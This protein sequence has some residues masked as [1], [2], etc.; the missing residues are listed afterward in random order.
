[1]LRKAFCLEPNLRKTNCVGGIKWEELAF[2]VP[3]ISYSGSLRG[4]Y[5]N[6]CE[7]SLKDAKNGRQ[8]LLR[9]KESSFEANLLFT[10]GM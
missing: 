2:E 9:Q 4:D 1:M 3:H 7:S 6:V 8:A 5:V 10:K